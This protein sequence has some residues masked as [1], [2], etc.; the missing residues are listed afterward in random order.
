MVS[1]LWD[2]VPQNQPLSLYFCGDRVTIFSLDG[3]SFG[4]CHHLE[5]ATADAILGSLVT[6]YERGIQCFCQ[7]KTVQFIQVD[8]C[9]AAMQSLNNV[10]HHA[11]AV[12]PSPQP[13]M[14][15][16]VRSIRE[17]RVADVLL[18]PLTHLGVRK[19]T[20]HKFHELGWGD[21]QRVVVAVD[22]VAQVEGVQN[23][24]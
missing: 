10:S 11:L 9:H 16:L 20:L 5:R 21:C 19:N 14:S 12:C 13:K 15:N 2:V 8:G 24:V 23:F 6:I 17:Q 18:N 3:Y 7:T 4:R 1:C 22:A